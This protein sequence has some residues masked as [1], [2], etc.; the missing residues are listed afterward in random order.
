MTGLGEINILNLNSAVKSTQLAQPIDSPGKTGEDLI[1]DKVTAT[2]PVSPDKAIDCAIHELPTT[3]YSLKDDLFHNTQGL[4][5]KILNSY[6]KRQLSWRLLVSILLFSS[7]I[8]LFGAG[9]QLFLDYQRDLVDIN[10]EITNIRI[11]H[12]GSLTTSLW[13]LDDQQLTTES[14]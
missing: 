13:K 4:S 9:L 1:T 6:L 14:L 10:D 12:L 8:T 11:T 5:R 3:E 2:S 7:V